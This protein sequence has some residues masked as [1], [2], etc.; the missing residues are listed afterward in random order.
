M[1]KGPSEEVTLEL[2]RCAWELEQREE[3]QRH[4]N[5]R[6]AQ[7]GSDTGCSLEAHARSGRQTARR[8]RFPAWT[9]PALPRRWARTERVLR[10]D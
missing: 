2:I 7:T 1:R 6:A 4:L 9:L 10:E 3:G 5:A 8:E